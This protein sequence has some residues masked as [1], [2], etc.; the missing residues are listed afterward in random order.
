MNKNTMTFKEFINEYWSAYEIFVV[1]DGDKEIELDY[2]NYEF[3]AKCRPYLKR[4]V[5]LEKCEEWNDI[6]VMVVLK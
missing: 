5:D 1:M 3:K 6:T 2:Y 4:M